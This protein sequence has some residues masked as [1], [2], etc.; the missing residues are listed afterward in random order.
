MFRNT[1]YL[2]YKL[3]L[4]ITQKT[5]YFIFVIKRGFATLNKQNQLTLDKNNAGSVSD[6]DLEIFLYVK[7]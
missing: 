7:I 1:Y 6:P 5:N 3:I 2:I 4:L